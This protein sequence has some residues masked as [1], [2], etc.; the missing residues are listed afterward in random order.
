MT[1]HRDL[2]VEAD[3]DSRGSSGT[4]SSSPGPDSARA[5]RG[6]DLGEPT[7]LVLIRHGRT[8]YTE[9]RRMSGTGGADPALSE[10]GRADAAA[11]AALLARLGG[12][13]SP[14]PDVGPVERLLCSPLLRTRQTAQAIADRLG[15][16]VAPDDGWAEIAFGEWDGLTYAEVAERWPTEMAAWQGSTTVAPPGGESLVDHAA[17][18]AKTRER[19][20]AEHP[21]AVVAVVAH[22]TPIRC[23]VAEALQ[24]GPAALWRMR[25]SPVSLTAVRYWSDGG[26][27][28][29]AVNRVP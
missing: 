9:E 29:L 27:E 16:A 8:P 26:A 6:V 12:P 15:L 11:V 19:L 2:A 20:V 14:L 22:V 5:P 21:G 10:A 18:I 24:A 23:V 7:V 1:S 3:G 4:V 28:V 17:R 13:D 25:V